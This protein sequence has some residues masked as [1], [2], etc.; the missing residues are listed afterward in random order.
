M[1]HQKTWLLG[2]GLIFPIYLYRKLQK[3]S[4]KNRWIEFIVTWQE[5]CFGD[6]L[7]RLFKLLMIRQKTWLPGGAGLIFRIYICIEN[8]KILLLR[9][10][11]T[12][13][14]I[15]WQECCFGDLLPRLFK[16]LMIRQKTWLPGGRGLF[17]VYISV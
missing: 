13:F 8:F 10:H 4:H 9:D 15:T 1:I 5:C 7:P 2:V 6:L 11:L 17:S 14:N 3:S 16:L 12:N